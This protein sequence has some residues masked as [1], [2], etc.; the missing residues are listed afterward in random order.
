[1]SDRNSSLVDNSIWLFILLMVSVVPSCNEYSED[2]PFL[3]TFDTQGRWGTGSSADVE[4]RVKDGVYEMLVK[5]NH[6]LYSATAGQ[7]FANAIYEVEVT[8][9]DGPL[10]NGFGLL[11]RVDEVSD[12]F[13]VFEISGDGYVWI[14][15]CNN[16]CDDEDI[17]LVGGDWFQSPVIRQGLQQTN[18]LKAIVEGSKM[19]FYIN[20]IEVGRSSDSRL[21]EGDVAVMVETLGQRGVRVIFDNFKVMPR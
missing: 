18:Q 20:G 19:T 4:G 12:T 15:Y 6:G 13:Y 14:G 16:R 11:F 21:T 7:E 10:N 3:E 5:N 9:V 8:Q 2:N 1:M 17:P